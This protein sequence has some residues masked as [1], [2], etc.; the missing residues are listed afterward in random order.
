MR[1][2]IVFGL[3]VQFSAVSKETET[4]EQCDD[5]SSIKLSFKARTRAR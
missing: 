5:I 2:I 1:K 3:D 4:Y